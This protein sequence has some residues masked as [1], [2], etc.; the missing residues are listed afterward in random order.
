[1][2]FL[3]LSVYIIHTLFELVFGVNAYLTG[4]SSSQSAEAIAAQPENL[5][6]AFR[7]Q[8]AALIALG[9]MGALV[10]LGPGVRSATARLIAAGFA[11]FHTLGAIGSLYTAAPTFAAY[12]SVLSIGAVVLHGVLAVGFWVIVSRPADRQ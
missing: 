11:V 8:G 1:M 9:L 3:A 10:I 5:T 4:A 7:F 2:R 6:I 12:D